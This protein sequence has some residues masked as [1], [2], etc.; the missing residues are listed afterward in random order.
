MN[1]TI[2][3]CYAVI[4]TSLTGSVLTLMWYL[5]GA[6]L[7]RIGFM[8][9]RHIL[10]RGVLFFYL[11]PM[12]Y[13]MFKIPSCMPAMMDARFF[14]S[15]PMILWISRVL[16]A[17]WMIGAIFFGIRHIGRVQ[18]LRKK[19]REAI[20]CE[21]SVQEYFEQ[22]CLELKVP[23][24]KVQLLQS[25][26]APVP[27]IMGVIHPKIILPVKA[28]SKEELRVIFLHELTHYKQGDLFGKSCMSIVLITNF[29]NPAAWWMNSLIGKWNEYACDYKAYSHA[30]GIKAYFDVIISMVEETG[31]NGLS[32]CLVENSVELEKRVK[33][34]SK[35]YKVRKYPKWIAAVIFC[36]MI[37]LSTSTVYAAAD[38]L[39]RGYIELYDNTVVNFD[40]TVNAN[41]DAELTE[42][43]DNGADESIHVETK[44]IQSMT[45]SSY[46]FCWEVPAN[47]MYQT[48]GF[49]ASSGGSITVTVVAD[50]D[51]LDLM[52]GI[53]Q[54]DGSRRYVT[55]SD[56]VTHQFALEQS[57]IYRVFVQND[58]SSAVNAEGTCIVK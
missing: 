29:F 13:V 22:I 58:N 39:G 57:G 32:V 42:Y 44:N 54:P 8:N 10:L 37:L 31:S 11:V 48:Q 46:G 27:A 35:F 4:L 40:E 6:L 55:G 2:D 1:W 12:A 9:I 7:E 17:L 38:F 33:H 24:G 20:P 51:N 16:V 23:A 45:R 30:G 26:H 53:V 36:V 18:S 25:Y 34:M 52:V 56:V 50:P 19:N 41:A 49:T 15:T 28:Y 47:T 21:R 5:V 3:F 14:A 43:Y